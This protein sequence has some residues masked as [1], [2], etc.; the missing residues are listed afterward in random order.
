[1]DTS[2][3]D[4][5]DVALSFLQD[6]V[7]FSFVVLV[8]VSS[9]PLS[10]LF[11]SSLCCLLAGVSVFVICCNNNHQR[12]RKTEFTCCCWIFIVVFCGW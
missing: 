2:L 5:H 12:R 1:M 9:V 6:F 11:F 10:P 3:I 8:S 4:A 7:A